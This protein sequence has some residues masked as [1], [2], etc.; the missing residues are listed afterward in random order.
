[1]IRA[2]GITMTQAT[3]HLRDI[4][5]E[6]WDPAQ[7]LK[8]SGHRLRPAL[9]LVA[10]VPLIEPRRI[11]D[12]GCGSGHFTRLLADR[13]PEATVVGMDNSPQ[14]LAKARA[15]PS[16]VHWEQGDLA[17]WQPAAPPSLLFS[18]AAIQWLPDHA[19]LIP[20]LWSL[21]PAG[22]CLAVQAPLSWDQPSHRLMRETLADGG[23]GGSRL[24]NDELRQA[25]EN[26]WLHEPGFYY[27]LLAP[28]AAHIEVW[29]TEYLHALIGPDPV[30]EW[31]TG[32]SMR[33][34]LTGLGDTDRAT[35]L[36]EYRRRL[37]DAYPR[38][39]DGITLYPFRRLFFVAVRR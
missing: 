27:D 23:A 29:S 1:M 32:T 26:R 14:M 7:Y 38:R 37:R 9:D 15:T 18:N 2:T 11:Y 35:F 21:L 6:S 16:R 24:G 30:L 8:F 5:G 17:H 20:R 4:A 12:L 28:G 36:A 13:W 33:P 31:V 25:V 22:G 10:R 19:T 3:A 39:G 34:I